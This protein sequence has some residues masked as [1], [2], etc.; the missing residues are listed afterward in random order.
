MNNFTGKMIE[1]KS[2]NYKVINSDSTFYTFIIWGKEILTQETT[3]G[4]YGTYNITS[5]S[6]LVEHIIEHTVNPQMNGSESQLRYEMVDENNIIIKWSMNNQ[7]WVSEKWSRL[8]LSLSHLKKGK[9]AN[10]HE[11]T[12]TL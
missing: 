7:K 6:T 2:G 8:P 12:V 9:A 11:Q 10:K 1:V 4:Q 5:D 3:I